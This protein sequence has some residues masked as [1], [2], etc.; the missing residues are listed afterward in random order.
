MRVVKLL[1]GLYVGFEAIANQQYVLLLLSVFFLY[2]GVFNVGHCGAN[3]CAV[4]TKR[5]TK[6]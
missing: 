6:F 1:M 5:K 3:G 2:Q 4:N